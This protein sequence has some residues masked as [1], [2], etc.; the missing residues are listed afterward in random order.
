MQ[1]SE[2]LR[3]RGLRPLRPAYHETPLTSIGKTVRVNLPSGQIRR[4]IVEY[5]NEDGTAKVWMQA[6]LDLAPADKLE[7][8]RTDVVSASLFNIDTQSPLQPVPHNLLVVLQH[9]AIKQS[10]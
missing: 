1:D 8:A 10:C 2:G 3:Q 9:F 6:T 7:P 5:V 4:A